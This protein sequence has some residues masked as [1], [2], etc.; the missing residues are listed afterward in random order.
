M[1]ATAERF[2]W[3]TVSGIG[4]YPVPMVARLLGEKQRV[5]R[6]WIE[7]YP[8]SDASPLIHRQLPRI[9]ERDVYG[10][11]DLVEAKFIKHFCDLGLSPQLIRKVSLKLRAKHKENHPFATKNRFRTD[12][13]KIFLEVVETEEEKRIID[14]MTDNFVMASVI[15]QSLFD[16]IL[17]AADLAYRWRPLREF[18]RI[19]LDPKIAFG[20]PVVDTAW[21][22]THTL[23]RSFLIERSASSVAD[24]FGIADDLV[25]EAVEFERFVIEGA[26]H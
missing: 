16:T 4:L 5:V 12:G 17:Y 21:V 23:Y 26:M 2:D 24:E 14:V 6:S 9:G 13:R 20:K 19:V 8:N 15:D 22:P 1:M 18:P 7:G 11:L 25:T 3:T 10:F